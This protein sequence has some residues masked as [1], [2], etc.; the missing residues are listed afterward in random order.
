MERFGKRLKPW[1]GIPLLL[2]A[3]GGG[4][5]S[6]AL[7]AQKGPKL[8]LD[9]LTVVT[10][11][12]SLQ[13]KVTASGTIEPIRSVNISPKNA[14][15]L[16][17]LYVEQGDSVTAGQLLARMESR[18]I[19]A[20]RTQAEGRIAQI[21]AKLQELAAGD[22]NRDND[23]AASRVDQAR[24]D[25]AAAESRLGEALAAFNNATGLRGQQRD[26][27]SEGEAQLTETQA[28]LNLARS[29][30]KRNQK[31]ALEG[32]ISR[33]RLDE[34]Q[35]TV[36]RA[37]A[38]VARAKAVANRVQQGISRV[39]SDIAAAQSR[40]R[41]AEI[42]VSQAQKRI[43]QSQLEL[44]RSLAPRR[45]EQLD[46]TRAELTQAQGQLQ[47]IDVQQSDTEIR[48][49]FSGTITQRYAQ[50]GAFVTPTTA[51]SSTASAT[52]TSIVAIAEGIE[53]IA[54][55][56]EV[57]VD[58]IKP[59]QAVEILVDAY[60]DQPFQGKV[61]LIAPAAI[62]E[63]NVTSFQIRV[64]VLDS[65]LLRSGMNADLTFLGGKTAQS[66]VVPT[67]AI[68]TQNGET[69]VILSQEGEPKFQPV[70]IGDTVD[71]KTQIIKGLGENDR[72]FIDIP[73]NDA[74]FK[75]FQAA[76]P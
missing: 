25:L 44:D 33:D 32:A 75:P 67:V 51:A 2:L 70:T 72:V 68:V 3:L 56:P 35:A 60:P 46:Q 19:S 13:R 66:L 37:E 58:Q 39:E 9:K 15:R 48:A 24:S 29:Q 18:D 57:D 31:L 64:S 11:R 42:S 47:L 43:A 12:E 59:G 22:S 65:K 55:I 14:G 74:R 6:I 26:S 27:V 1:M 34:L 73:P 5:G 7:N 52:S 61:R 20:Q 76:T 40:V 30:F 41:Q 36:L 38:N 45:P 8:D 71:N 50:P 49:P 17:E 62:K 54:N 28:T 4:V 10:K 16:V 21:Q 63:Q 53:V 23:I 69:G